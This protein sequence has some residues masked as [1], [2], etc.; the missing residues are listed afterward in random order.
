MLTDAAKEH[1]TLKLRSS[2]SHFGMK[3]SQISS[4]KIFQDAEDVGI[5]LLSSYAYDILIL[6]L[7]LPTLNIC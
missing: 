7:Q 3:Q 4:S 1:G 2:I 6:G 5:Y